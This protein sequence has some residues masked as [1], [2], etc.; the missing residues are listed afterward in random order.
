MKQL[1]LILLLITC[2][3]A[4]LKISAD[5]STTL[6]NPGDTVIYEVTVSTTDGWNDSVPTIPKAE[7]YDS[8]GVVTKKFTSKS[9]TF[10]N[11]E[12]SE[13]TNYTLHYYYTLVCRDREGVWSIGPATVERQ[14]KLYKSDLIPFQIG[15]GLTPVKPMK[16]AYIMSVENIEVAVPFELTLRTTMPFKSNAEFTKQS[17]NNIYFPLQRELMQRDFFVEPLTREYKTKIDTVDDMPCRVIDLRL[18]V[19]PQ[20]AG[21]Q[22]IPSLP[23]VYNKKKTANLAESVFSTSIANSDSV[24]TPELVLN[25]LPKGG[26]PAASAEIPALPVTVNK[27]LIAALATMALLMILFF[28]A[29]FIKAKRT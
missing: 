2:A 7:F 20:S 18:R 8:A 4:E 14:G 13:E 5:I 24:M 12:R 17:Y 15:D 1:T 23:L 6:A 21:K 10:I 26:K 11:G 16:F 3:F 29:G 25:V 28:I 9:I 22:T 27:T 19:T